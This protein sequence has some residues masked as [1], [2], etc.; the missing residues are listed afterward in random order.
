M[1]THPYQKCQQRRNNLDWT[2]PKFYNLLRKMASLKTWVLPH[3]W[4][5][6]IVEYWNVDFNE[7]VTLLL[8]S[9]TLVVNMNFANEATR[10]FALRAKICVWLRQDQSAS[11]SALSSLP[12]GSG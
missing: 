7:K 9:F 1:N 3:T 10:A 4:N 12:K 11:S 5:N 8:T 2:C 6:G